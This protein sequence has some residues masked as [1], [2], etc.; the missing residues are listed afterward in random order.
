MQ[1]EITPTEPLDPK[2]LE[3]E[4]DRELFREVAAVRRALVEHRKE[5]ASRYGAVASTM[6]GLRET[7]TDLANGLAALVASHH[8]AEKRE[9]ERDR[10]LGLIAAELGALRNESRETRASQA[11]FTNEIESVKK[12][13]AWLALVGAWVE[14]HQRAASVAAFLLLLAINAI[15]IVRAEMRANS[16]NAPPAAAQ[17]K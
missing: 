7:L 16:H 13:T 3:E 12:R 4:T 17:G 14:R 6:Q 2:L 5:S 10:Q 1:S 15:Q 11:S 9:A 8:R